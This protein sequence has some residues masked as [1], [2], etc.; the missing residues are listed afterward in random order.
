MIRIIRTTLVLL[1]GWSILWTTP[2]RAALEIMIT[3]G[4][5][6]ARP[7]AVVP[8]QWPGTV[9][10][11]VD[12]AA[13][14]GNDLRNSG[15]F[16]PVS[17][18]VMPQTPYRGEDVK[19]DAWST[20]GAEAVVVG[21]VAP[22]GDGFYQI[23]F[24]LLDVLRGQMLGENLQQSSDGQLVKSNAHILASVTAKVTEKQLRQYAHRI[25]DIVYEKL[26]GEK[27][28]F[29]T[30]IAYVEVN[31]GAK[32]PFRLMI[33]DY[34]GYN[35]QAVIRSQQPL[36]SPSWSPDG[37]KLAYVSFEKQQSEIFIQDIYNRERIKVSS[38]P[39]I[40]GAPVWSPDGKQLALVLSKEGQ[41]DIYLMDVANRNLRQVTFGRTIDTEPSWSPDGKSLIFSSERGGK[42]QIYQV[43]LSSGDIKRLTWEGEMNLG[44]SITPDGKFLLMVSRLKGQYRIAKQ[45]LERNFVQV[46][47]Q[48]QLDESP[49]IAPNG[50]MIIYSTVVGT[51]QVLALVSMDGRFKAT[52][53]AR[54]GEVR[55]PAW[56]P[57]IN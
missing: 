22:S 56:S 55:A 24:E 3:E 46:L 1:L 33:S 30:R 21:Q 45:D 6:G 18:N 44:G 32:Y 27:G 16:A 43:N 57:F 42:P 7:V 12:L 20:V 38:F 8:F 54:D 26:T 41:P 34:D 4:I 37:R 28:A 39:G 31:H 15:K 48:T 29:L 5:S 51:K 19:F 2:S 47:T 13:V 53:P 14:I 40:N 10:L 9:P 25:A 49:S 17:R 23:S 50:S 52:L 36:M 11:P 35:E